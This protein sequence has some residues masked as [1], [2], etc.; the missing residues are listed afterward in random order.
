MKNDLKI[1]IIIGMVLV[2]SI[3]LIISLWPGQSVDQR[4]RDMFREEEVDLP[5]NTEQQKTP[6]Q[7]DKPA[8]P[9]PTKKTTRTKI[10][11]TPT[12]T[13]Q[14]IHTVTSGETL[15]SIAMKYYGTTRHTQIISEANRNKITDKNQIRPGM[16]LIIPKIN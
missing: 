12:T 10:N 11:K 16:R 8:T 15:S 2:I 9:E 4:H 6:P 13:P 3:V 1:G 5:V 14:R 7:Q